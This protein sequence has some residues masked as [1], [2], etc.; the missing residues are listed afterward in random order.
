MLSAAREN[1]D[2]FEACVGT[3]RVAV[4]TAIT[5]HFEALLNLGRPSGPD[6]VEWTKGLVSSVLD[7]K[8][9]PSEAIS[10]LMLSFGKEPAFPPGVLPDMRYD[11]DEALN[12]LFQP[13]E[14][15]LNEISQ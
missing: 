6:L 12:R 3:W 4:T 1:A 9:R 13:V 14:T 10:G 8:R 5:S 2:H 7:K 15:H 11:L